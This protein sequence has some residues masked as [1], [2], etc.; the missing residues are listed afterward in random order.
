MNRIV[1][2]ILTALFWCSCA[3]DQTNESAS[4]T[5]FEGADQVNFDIL[6][7]KKSGVDF[8]NTLIETESENNYTFA[9]FLNG[10]GAAIADFNNDGLQDLFFTSNQGLDQIY[11]N[12]GNL[13]FENITTNSGISSKSW[14]A[15]VSTVDINGDGF[16][17]IYIA[18]GSTLNTPEQNKNQLWINNGDLTFT[19]SAESYNIDCNGY[20]VHS[21]FFDYDLDGDLDLYV[22]NFPNYFGTSL[23][24]KKPNTYETDRLYR[25]N[26]DGSF[27]DMTVTMNMT[28]Y[29]HGLGITVG[30]FDHNNYPDIYVG[31]DFQYPDFAYYNQGGESFKNVI[32]DKFQHTTEFS[33]GSDAADI[34]NDGYL[35]I[36]SADM[37][38]E[39]NYR[40]KSSMPSMNPE[41]FWSR[42]QKGFHY[43]YMRNQLHRNQG[44]GSFSEIGRQLQVANTDWSWSPLLIDMNNDGLRDLY[45]TN[46][47]FRDVG[48]KDFSKKVQTWQ[49]KNIKKT[50]MEILSNLDQVK[51]D[52]YV[53]KNNGDLSFTDMR[54]QWIDQNETFS[55]G[56]AYGDLDN[57]G[58]I[59]IIVNNINQDAFVLE[60]KTNNKNSLRIKLKGPEKNTFGL[61]TKLLLKSKSGIQF[62]EMQTSRGYQSSSEPIVHFG[63]GDLNQADALEIYWPDGKYQELKDIKNGVVTVDYNQANNN[64]RYVPNTKSPVTFTKVNSG[65]GI[66]FTHKENKFDDYAKQVLLPHQMSRFGPALA[67]AD[68]NGDGLEDVYLGGAKGQ[69]SYLYDQQSDGTFKAN[70]DFKYLPDHE[71]VDALFFD[72]SLNGSPDLYVSVGDA[73]PASSASL[74]MD[75]FYLNQGTKELIPFVKAIPQSANAGGPVVDWDIDSDGDRDLV[76]GSRVLPDQYPYSPNTTILKNENNGFLDISSNVG[77]ALQKSGMISDMVAIDLNGDGKEEL[78]TCGEWNSVKVFGHSNGEIEDQTSTYLDRNMIGWWYSMQKA[79]LDGDGDL[80]IVC[81]N[82]G[83]N[84]KYYASE[85]KPFK[86]FAKDFDNNGTVDIVLG[87]NY[88]DKIYPVRGLQC[89]S[90]QMPFVKEEIKSYNVFGNATVEDVYG[91]RLDDALVINANEFRSM[92]LWNEGGRLVAK[93]LPPNA[94]SFPIFGIVSTDLNGD[95]K[96]DLILGGN[97]KIA[98][99]ETGNNDAGKGLVL[100]NNGDQTFKTLNPYQ[101]GLYAD[102]DVR[103]MELV[104]TSKGKYLIIANNNEPAEVYKVN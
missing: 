94:Q 79:D 81:G 2:I 15:G 4:N 32:L 68:Y 44:D 46:G 69:S 5:T 16:M 99:V 28:N 45:I 27:T 65:L 31:N 49:K 89:S 17:D 35:D 88:N 91:D 58:D 93:P 53:F 43:Q 80:D 104:T 98:E 26:G 103:N 73:D 37:N 52:N 33:M 72:A 78:I 71:D 18:K 25:N 20:S 101:T 85:D 70:V 57:D 12:K 22:T 13:E 34:D 9:Y 61:G 39:D 23:E 30:D 36:F 90:E 59:D 6:P 8:Q 54:G 87:Y 92:V 62:Q 40:S 48:N 64:K 102:G 3:S 77:A 75:R 76:V 97:L 29:G 50:R 56:S 7:S 14:S 11:L 60:N 41:K 24:T 67:V 1:F 86:V 84:Y 42:V 21:A 38:P 95:G 74:L 100:L 66:D 96:E 63:M 83:T 10:G 82:L 47:Y 55:N 19:E 51:L